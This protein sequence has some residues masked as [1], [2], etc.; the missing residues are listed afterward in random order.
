ML[1]PALAEQSGLLHL[2]EI[3]TAFIHTPPGIP[4][5][6]KITKDPGNGYGYDIYVNGKLFVH[7]PFVPGLSGVKGFSRK[8]DAR[9]VAIL[10]VKKINLGIMPPTIKREELDSLKIKY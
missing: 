10:V 8:S 5:Q 6:Y 3:Q 7:Q 4:C 1:N 9:K 2:P